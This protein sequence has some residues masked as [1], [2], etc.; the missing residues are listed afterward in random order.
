MT[1]VIYGVRKPPINGR[2]LMSNWGEITGAFRAHLVPHGLNPQ[3]SWVESS[4]VM[5]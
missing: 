2:K 1:I 4:K 5:G 3:K